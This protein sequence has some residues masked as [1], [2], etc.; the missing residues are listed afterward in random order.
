MFS[1]VRDSACVEGSIE[2]NK[3]VRNDSYNLVE[4]CN[5]GKWTSVCDSE[6]SLE[7]V[8]TICSQAGYARRGNLCVLPV[9]Y[10]LVHSCIDL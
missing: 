9:L 2:L 4:I 6:W 10:I 7:D 3:G 1:A 8:A 5:S